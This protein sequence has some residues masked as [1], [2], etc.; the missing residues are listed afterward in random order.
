MRITVPT[1]ASSPLLWFAVAG[2]PAAWLFQFGVSYWLA[3]A[4]CSV[5]GRDAGYSI[6]PW[7]IA[8]GGVALAVGA[9]ALTVAIGIWRAT[10]DADHDTQPPLGRVHFLATIGIAIA[11]LF[12]A[13]IAMNAVGVGILESCNQS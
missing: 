8:A 7:V 4:R 2:A 12:L 11:P 10:S 6:D 3:E 13:I 9:L 1:S 5:S